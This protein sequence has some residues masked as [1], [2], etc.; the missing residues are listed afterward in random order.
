MQPFD[1]PIIHKA[2]ELFRAIHALQKTVPK[3]ERFTLW[4]RIE[5]VALDILQGFLRAGYLPQESRAEAL[6]S[7]S[8]LV[9][10]LR[11]LIRLSSDVKAISQKQYLLLQQSI[12]EIGRMLGGWLKS[13]KQK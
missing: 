10:T 1:I 6:I 8:V 5:N 3:M 11:L 4:Q 7:T 12:D 13:I 2:Y 9:D